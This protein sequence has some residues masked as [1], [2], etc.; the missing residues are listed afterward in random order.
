MKNTSKLATNN[1]KWETLLAI[2]AGDT[3]DA[4]LTRRSILCIYHKCQ[5]LYDRLPFDCCWL[6]VAGEALQKKAGK[7]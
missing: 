2:D 6:L 3:K 4:H 1:P 5:L 7:A